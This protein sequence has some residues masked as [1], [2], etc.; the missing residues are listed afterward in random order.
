MLTKLTFS[1]TNRR[2][3]EAEALAG[4]G[5]V[6]AVRHQFLIYAALGDREPRRDCYRRRLTDA[7]C[8]LYSPL[9]RLRRP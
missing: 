5:D 8:A 2:R 3:R 1:A 6:A 4:E 7:V 9:Q